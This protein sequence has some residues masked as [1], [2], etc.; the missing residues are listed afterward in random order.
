MLGAILAMGTGIFIFGLGVT[1]IF[2]KT[3]V[4]MEEEEQ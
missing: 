1:S 2:A 4:M 3:F